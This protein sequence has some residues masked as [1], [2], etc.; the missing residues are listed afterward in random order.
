[1]QQ[2]HGKALKRCGNWIWVGLLANILGWLSPV[3][4]QVPGAPPAGASCV[5][6]AGNR[7]APLAA[8]GSYTVFAIPG[9]LGAIRARA[10]CSDGSVGQSQAA[11][12]NPFAPDTIE[13]GPISFG[14]IDPVPVAAA[15]TAPS[16]LLGTGDDSQL[17]MT[18]IGLDGSARDV[19]PRIE[20]TVYSVSNALLAAVSEDGLVHIFPEFAPG[21]SARLV[22]SATTE[23]SVSAT[24][25]YTLGPRGTL[26]GRV[27]H[28]DGSTP[29][30]GVE[31][32]VLRLQPVE[33]VGTAIADAD[34]RFELA[35]VSAG[36]FMLS[37]L[38]R[39]TGDR[40]LGFA[41]IDN[42]GQA[43]HV[44]L[45]MNG[46]ST[47]QVRVIDALGQAVA[48]AEVTL[49]ALGAFRDTR[50]LETDPDGQVT[51]TAITAGDFTVSARQAATRLVGATV[52]RVAASESKTI[53]L[54]LQPVGNIAGRVFDI[55]GSS[56]KPGVQVRILSR[57]RG[58][59]T[60]TVVGDDAS[61]QFDTLPLSDGPYTLDAFVD[62]R[63][64]ARVPGIVLP[65]AN[66]TVT[67][68]IQ[69][70]MVGVVQGSVLNLAGER[71][72]N[73]V[74]S[75]QS[76]VGLRI[77]F[78]ART[79]A[80]GRFVLPAVPV[81]AFELTA[82]TADGQSGR[83]QGAIGQDGET[84]TTDVVIAGNTIVGTVFARDGV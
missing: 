31:V 35:D 56:L 48:G 71:F 64:R 26:T 84:V 57:E 42:E 82:I 15:L 50:L 59:L 12:T 30:A 41:R 18:A 44:D 20:G 69:L 36:P 68:D 1:M 28:A 67:Q 55:D 6:S 76:L 32:S 80:G 40:A 37:A 73:A 16:R 77:S 46:Q 75:V 43:V 66:A 54:K 72:A 63:L 81:G 21:S 2:T 38:E 47:V 24:L 7:N 83:S 29:V 14:H 19:T 3:L 53:T 39:G 49:T 10:T 70:G 58:I 13:L 61:F 79:D 23:G 22:A 78:E 27:L 4:A 34:G 17:T 60:Q 33:Q 62:G 51:F 5:V 45:L 8:D 11:F 25:V 52:D 65:A 74:V 9:N